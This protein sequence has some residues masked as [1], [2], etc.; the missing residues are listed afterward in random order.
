[1]DPFD[2][3]LVSG[4][5]FVRNLVGLATRPYE[6]VRRIVDRGGLF[7]LF[8]IAM[9]LALYFALASLVKEASFRPFLL[10]RHF[11]VLG[12]TAGASF[13]LVSA[14]VWAIGTFVGGKGTFS[15][16]VLAWGYTLIPTLVWF[17][18][19]SVLYVLLPPPRTTQITGIV[20]SIVY[21]VFSITLL[22]WKI[23][24]GYLAVRF[25]LRLD[26]AKI[27]VVVAIAAPMFTFYSFVMYR[28]GVFKVPFL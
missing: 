23:L 16:F 25:S 2:Q 24:L 10:T 26:L 13:F 4:I 27:A 20:F 3:L 18:A 1:M 11:L 22:F 12:A 7:E 28:L 17:L 19:T 21:L 8:F 15:R 14:T 5:A 6:T 9:L